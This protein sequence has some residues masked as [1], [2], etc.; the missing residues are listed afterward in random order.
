MFALSKRSEILAVVVALLVSC[1]D[2]LP[3]SV[4]TDA[5]VPPDLHG[6]IDIGSAPD[7]PLDHDTSG[8]ADT[9]VNDDA[10]VAPDVVPE[11]A[12]EVSVAVDGRTDIAFGVCA[13]D[14]CTPE[15]FEGMAC[16]TACGGPVTWCG[17]C[18]CAAGS[19]RTT[20]CP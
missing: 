19:I 17:C 16:V 1:G 7:I 9:T 5:A 14:K 10:S 3:K 6:E 20:S 11:A 18:N 13:L 8:F 2:S 12:S 15:C 4:G